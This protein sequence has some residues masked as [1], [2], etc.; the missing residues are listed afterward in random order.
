MKPGSL[1]C[2]DAKVVAVGCHG[3]CKK[4]ELT[5]VEV[6]FQEERYTRW[7]TVA[8]LRAYASKLAV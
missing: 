5:G 4:F 2:E 7:G 8:A 6:A 1:S 3:L